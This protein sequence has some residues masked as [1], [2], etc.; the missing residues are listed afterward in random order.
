[1]KMEHQQPDEG[2]E[3]QDRID[4]LVDGELSSEERVVLFEELDQRPGEW[5][6][7]A[8]TYVEAG[9]LTEALREPAEQI[10]KNNKVL[11]FPNLITGWLAATAMGLAFVCGWLAAPGEGS[12][13]LAG[14]MA[15]PSLDP[16]GSRVAV[17]A[18]EART[19]YRGG[20]TMLL[21]EERGEG[22]NVLST[23]HELPGFV[24]TALQNAGHQ[25]ERVERRVRLPGSERTLELPVVETRIVES[26]PF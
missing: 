1:M 26:G 13:A 11:P 23:R 12:P 10:R 21:R 20:P 14:S 22:G 7:C 24:L 19:S 15:G 3:L 4:L 2:A 6:A 16:R 9:V 17:P 18:M 8:L 25:V 5:R